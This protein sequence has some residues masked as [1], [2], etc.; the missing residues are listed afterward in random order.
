MLGLAFAWPAS[1]AQNL[2]TGVFLPDRSPQAIANHQTQVGKHQDIFMFYQAWGS[3]GGDLDSERA[4]W[5]IDNGSIPMITWEP[6]A[7]GGPETDQPD[8]SLS[9]IIN[10]NHDTYIRKFAQQVK[11]VNGTIYLRTMH[12]MNGNW[13]PWC[14]T[15]NGNT[16]SQYV[17]AYRHI[18]DVFRQEGVSNVRW[19]WSPNNGGLPDWGTSSMQSYYPGDN[20]VDFTA[21]DGYNFGTTDSWSAWA[22]FTDV[23]DQAYQTI[24][25]FSQK[26]MIIAE[27]SSAEAGG[28]KANWIRNTFDT[29]KTSYPK[30][31]AVIWFNEKQTVDWRINSSPES[32]AAYKAALADLGTTPPAPPANPPASNPT[33]TESPT[34]SVTI[35][36]G[37]GRTTSRNVTLG[38][39]GADT[40]G[41]GLAAMRLRNHAGSWS[42][43]EP[44]SATKS[45]TL[46]GRRGTKKV[47]LQLKDGAGNLS[48]VYSDTVVYGSIR[49]KV[50][51]GKARTLSGKSKKN[52]RTVSW[53][54]VGKK[55]SRVVYTVKYRSTKLKKKKWKTLKV[56]TK[57]TSLRF[58]IKK[59]RTYFFKV[60]ARDADGNLGKS[61]VKKMRVH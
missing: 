51:V 43:W 1:A 11:Q 61:R 22:S 54:T 46:R 37:A 31:T 3:Y 47:D 38:L 59:H 56:K 57:K 49:V 48:P 2:Q 8:Y 32:L 9:K 34:G 18:V 25:G 23:F 4:Q 30:I 16:P 5:I 7:W 26:P 35:N 36:D 13:Y 60:V 10:G 40:G 24:T 41:S 28:N 17:P 50:K 20:Y 27:M 33:D 15:V 52:M 6:W 44:F 58:K 29:I 55:T 12:E 42:S 39:Q 14:G 53:G 45:W 19:V 21:V